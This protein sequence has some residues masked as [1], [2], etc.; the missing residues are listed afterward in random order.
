MHTPSARRGPRRTSTCEG[1]HA[2]PLAPS[3]PLSRP[4]IATR[5]ARPVRAHGGARTLTPGR[6]GDACAPI[7]RP[8]S[9]VSGAAHGQKRRKRCRVHAV[10]GFPPAF[11]IDRVTSNRSARGRQSDVAGGVFVQHGRLKKRNHGSYQKAKIPK[12]EVLYLRLLPRRKGTRSRASA[13][14]RRSPAC[15]APCRSPASAAPSA[16]QVWL[17]HNRRLYHIRAR[18][19]P[20]LPWMH[21]VPAR[22]LLE[23]V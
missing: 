13:A 8:A 16:C 11:Y 10:P 17:Y 23:R 9:G 1:A 21:S 12:Q 3:S 18:R 14:P 22:K 15:A 20:M 7:A 5:G 2:R 4:I 6:W 19:P